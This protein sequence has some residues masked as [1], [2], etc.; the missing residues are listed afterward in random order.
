MAETATGRLGA[1]AP[2]TTLTSI[3]APASGKKATVTINFANREASANKIRVAFIDA[4]VT[5][6]SDASGSVA[7]ED[8]LLYDYDLVANDSGNITGIAIGNGETL[9]VYGED[10]NVSFVCYGVEEDL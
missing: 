8:Y 3:Y 9:A 1:Q 5:A 10:T 4:T 6:G 2:G 7:N